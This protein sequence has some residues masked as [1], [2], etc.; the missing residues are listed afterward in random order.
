MEIPTVSFAG[1]CYGLAHFL[2]ECVDSIL[3]QSFKNIEIIILDYSSDNT[4]DAS[5]AIFS[6]HSDRKIVFTRSR[7]NFDKIRNYNKGICIAE[8]K[9]VWILSRDDRLVP[10]YNLIHLFRESIT[11][12]PLASSWQLCKLGRQAEQRVTDSNRWFFRSDRV[13]YGKEEDNEPR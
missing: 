6:N 10:C 12:E 13:S 1:P 3:S 7:E 4:A 9:R 2:A 5:R 8:R 11:S